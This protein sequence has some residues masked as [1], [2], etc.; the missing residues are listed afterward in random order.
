V[1]YLL[2]QASPSSTFSSIAKGGELPLPTLESESMRIWRSHDYAGFS[3]FF[4]QILGHQ[5]AEGIQK[6]H[7]NPLHDAIRQSQ[8]GAEDG[9]HLLAF[10]DAIR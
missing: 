3:G 9:A 6:V 8:A 1:S 10:V 5:A 2:I 4:R 7:E